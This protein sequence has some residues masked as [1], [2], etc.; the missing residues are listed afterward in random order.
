MRGGRD[1]RGTWRK[2]DA[3]LTG[4]R[5]FADTVLWEDDATGDT[6]IAGVEL[7]EAANVL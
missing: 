7:L 4:V 2:L 1:I 5:C 6:V 3:F